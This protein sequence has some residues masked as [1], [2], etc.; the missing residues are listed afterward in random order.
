MRYNVKDIFNSPFAV[1]Y[2]KVINKISSP[3]QV[4]RWRRKLIEDVLAEVGNCKIVVDYCSGACN[5]G[6]ILRS[7]PVPSSKAFILNCDISRPLLNL[8]KKEF[9]QKTAFVCADNRFFPVKNSYVDVVFSSFCVRNSPEPERTVEEVYRVLKP[10]GAW[11]ILDFFRIK[12]RAPITAFNDF[13]FRSFMKLNGVLVPSHK[14]AIDYLFHSIEQ[15]YT[16]DE[17]VNLLREKGFDVK[18]VRS[19]MGGVAN[20]LVAIKQEVN[21]V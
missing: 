14:E 6:K 17:F 16:I 19:Y 1:F 2:E 10:G 5:M 3:V 11:G 12:E 21:Y 13:I 4:D 8:G 18:L 15:F 20:T 7:L 9:S